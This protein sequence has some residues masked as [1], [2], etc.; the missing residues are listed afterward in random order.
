[1]DA[2]LKSFWIL[3]FYW[4]SIEIVF[5]QG[6]YQSKT[7]DNNKNSTAFLTEGSCLSETF[8]ASAFFQDTC[9]KGNRMWTDFVKKEENS[10]IRSFAM[11]QTPLI[12]VT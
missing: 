2:L 8:F 1:M 9:S 5:E 6:L 4:F 10:T 11:S 3:C 12:R 7:V